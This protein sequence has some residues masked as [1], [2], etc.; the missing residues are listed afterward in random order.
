MLDVNGGAVWSS[1]RAYRGVGG[2]T[3]EVSYPLGE[4]HGGK[5]RRTVLLWFRGQRLACRWALCGSMW[6]SLTTSRQP[7][8][9]WES[10]PD[11]APCLVADMGWWLMSSFTLLYSLVD[12]QLRCCN[13][14][15][16]AMSSVKMVCTCA[17]CVCVLMKFS[18]DLGKTDFIHHSCSLS[19]TACKVFQ[20]CLF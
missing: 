11:R 6:K 4:S 9:A 5:W 13:T 18:I 19:I 15:S 17:R 1:P 20:S 2:R 3:I 8:W 7:V 12:I 16:P 10:A 14:K